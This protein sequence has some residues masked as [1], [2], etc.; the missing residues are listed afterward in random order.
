MTFP[1]PA[2]GPKHHDMFHDDF[3]FMGT[4]MRFLAA[5]RRRPASVDGEFKTQ[6]RKLHTLG[7]EA[8]PMR[9]NDGDDALASGWVDVRTDDEVLVEFSLVALAIPQ[10]DVGA[11][12]GE[13]FRR[14]AECLAELL[15]FEDAVVDVVAAVHRDTMIDRLGTPQ[16]RRH[17]ND[18]GASADRRTG[19]A[20]N[21]GR[22]G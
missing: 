15:E 2:V 11:N 17:L 8:I 10:T 16:F 21:S 19:T 5:N 9:L 14:M 6:D 20:K 4:A 1:D 22:D 13:R 7:I 12:V 18:E 3:R